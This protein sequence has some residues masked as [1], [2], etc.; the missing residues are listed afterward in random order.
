M[1]A[2]SPPKTGALLFSDQERL[3]RLLNDETRP[4]QFVFAGKAHPQD[5]GGKALIQQVYKFSRE[6]GFENRMVFVEDYD[7]YI[8]RRLVQ[9]V[10]LWLNNPLRPLE[11]SGTSGMKLPPN[12]GLNLSVL[13]GWWCESYNGNNGWA[14]GAEIAGGTVDFQSEVDAGSLYQLLENQIIP[15]YYAKPDGKLPL[16]WL[17]LMRESIRTVT[18][19]F[20]THRMVKEYTER[21]YTPAAKAHQEFARD[22]CAAATNLSK[23]KA[24]MRK[25]WPQVTILDVQVGNS[26]RQNIQVGEALQISAKVHLGAVVPGHVRVEAYHGEAD[27]GGIRNPSVTVLDGSSPAEGDGNYLY[28]GSVPASDSGAYGFSV[29]VF[30]S[31][32]SDATHDYVVTCRKSTFIFRSV[33]MLVIPPRRR[34]AL[35]SRKNYSSSASRSTAAALRRPAGILGYARPLGVPRL[36]ATRDDQLIALE[37]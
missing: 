33:S 1:P 37:R 8:A 36:C 4:V 30:R 27:N 23:W 13:D 22:G 28:Q 34:E 15:L 24:Q 17:Q 31:I 9:G 18:P 5:E 7:T 14:I 10:D 11:A 16:A 12:G 6:K 26:D 2:A 32:P 3:K 19:V 20:N 25:D 21:L 29:R 35:T